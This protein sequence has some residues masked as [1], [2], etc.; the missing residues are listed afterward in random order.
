MMPYLNDLND[1]K[2]YYKKYFFVPSIK[3][4]ELL[5]HITETTYLQLSEIHIVAKLLT[6]E[7]VRQYAERLRTDGISCDPYVLLINRKLG[8]YIK[9]KYFDK[10][11]DNN[12]VV[13]E[14]ETL[15]DEFTYDGNF[16]FHPVLMSSSSRHIKVDIT[17]YDKRSHDV[18]KLSDGKLY[19]RLSEITQE[20]V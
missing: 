17:F 10:W 20:L 2:N 6:T 4:E 1:N 15:C 16:F 3:A 13:V 19:S 8:E 12:D 11:S 7:S 5:N 18:F 9:K 14:N